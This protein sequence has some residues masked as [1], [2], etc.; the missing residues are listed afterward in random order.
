MLLG[1]VVGV[2][3]LAWGA[4]LHEVAVVGSVGVVGDEPA[5]DLGA[6]LG[7]PVEASAVECGSPAFLE[8]GALEPFAHRVVVR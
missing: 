2:E 6:Q 8:C 5:V 1:S 4:A 7:E 3:D